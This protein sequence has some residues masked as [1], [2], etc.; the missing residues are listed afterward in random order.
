MIWWGILNSELGFCNGISCPLVE[1]DDLLIMWHT[2]E[3]KKKRT[4]TPVTIMDMA[5]WLNCIVFDTL[6]TCTVE[7]VYV[8][9]LMRLMNFEGTE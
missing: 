7:N 1:K 5:I 2:K 3:T 6:D 9:V 4:W 8:S